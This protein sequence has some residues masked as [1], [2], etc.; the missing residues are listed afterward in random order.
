MITNDHTP[1][2]IV[3][4]LEIKS[5]M[6]GFQRYGPTVENLMIWI[7]FKADLE[8]R[9]I[10]GF[11]A[12]KKPLVGQ[13]LPKSPHEYFASGNKKQSAWLDAEGESLD[14]PFKVIQ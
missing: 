1:E 14:F 6:T 5:S 3:F 2:S 13:N 11:A 9:E 10:N 7:R 8:W 4:P 12:S